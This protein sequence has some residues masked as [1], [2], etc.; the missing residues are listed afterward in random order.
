MKKVLCYIA[1]IALLAMSALVGACNP[2]P[3]APEVSISYKTY[4][5]DE[6][7]ENCF[8]SVYQL[9]TPYGY[10]IT[11][12][13]LMQLSSGSDS[14][15]KPYTMAE[16]VEWIQNDE[17]SYSIE[18]IDQYTTAIK[19]V[20]VD[21]SIYSQRIYFNVLDNPTLQNE[22]ITINCKITHIGNSEAGLF[23]ESVITIVDDEHAPR[24]RTGYYNTSYTPVADAQNPTAGNFYLQLYKTGKY[25]YVA[26]GWFGL[27]RPRLVG[28]FDPA[29]RTLSFDGTDYDHLSLPDS[30]K[31]NAFENDSLWLA[32]TAGT[33]IL[34]F[35]GAGED[36]REPIVISTEDIAQ[37]AEGV[38]LNITT[39][40]GFEIYDLKSGKP[41][42]LAGYWDGMD[43]SDKMVHSETNYEVPEAQQ[44][45]ANRTTDLFPIPYTS[46]HLTAI[47]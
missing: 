16:V 38:L 3:K 42:N 39:P 9:N 22:T 8:I 1:P 14:N 5:F 31:V 20:V 11:V 25:E 45:A 36:K 30:L 47:E 10:P 4:D 44:A 15:G 12:D 28:T 37:D 41:D 43:H 29:K 26:A 34:R 27:P 19:G 40:C 6:G 18:P 13:L 33:Q 35:Y 2:E 32:N 17:T 21:Y 24:I 23:E 7:E 46:W